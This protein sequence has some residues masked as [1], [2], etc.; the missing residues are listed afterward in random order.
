MLLACFEVAAQ[1]SK[2]LV[3]I[4][5]TNPN[6]SRAQNAFFNKIA[7]IHR[8]VIEKDEIKIIQTFLFCN[9]VNNNKFILEYI[10]EAKRFDGTI[11]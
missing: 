5:F 10:L 6:F 8:S 4:S 1:Q 2:L 3:I 9:S 11:F 7:S